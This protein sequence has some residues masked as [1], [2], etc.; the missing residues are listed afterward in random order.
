M[1]LG[2]GVDIIEIERV[3]AVF[4]EEGKRLRVFTPG[5]IA[6]GGKRMESLAGCFAAKE[7]F[8]KALGT[9]IRGLGLRD[10]EV[11]KDSLGKPHIRIQ[12]LKSLLEERFP[13][14]SITLHLSIA[15]H[16][17]SAVAMVVIEGGIPC[18]SQT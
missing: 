8:S 14:Q 1:I 12:P 7:A 6:R 18:E 10:I 17:T 3:A 4:S 9:G 15:H 13:G 2:I 11:E 16:R 5:E